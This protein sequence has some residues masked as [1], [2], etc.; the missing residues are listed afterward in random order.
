LH[1]ALGE[2][3]SQHTAEEITQSVSDPKF[4]A[5]LR[6]FTQIA[7]DVL[8][9]LALALAAWDGVFLVGSVAK[10]FAHAADRTAFREAF[11]NKGPMKHWMQRIPL[12]LIEKGDASL[13]GLAALSLRARP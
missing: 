9:N 1:A 11:E 6:L 3:A 12:A 10:G 5:T 7:G 2:D 8:G 4:A 13:F